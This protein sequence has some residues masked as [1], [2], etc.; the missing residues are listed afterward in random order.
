MGQESCDS[1]S[2][3]NNSYIHLSMKTKICRIVMVVIVIYIFIIMPLVASIELSKEANIKLA[4]MVECKCN[5]IYWTSLKKNVSFI[6][7]VNVYCNNTNTYIAT[8]NTFNDVNY[9]TLIN[10]TCW[11]DNTTIVFTKNISNNCTTK[12]T[13]VMTEYHDYLIVLSP[14]DG[15]SFLTITGDSLPPRWITC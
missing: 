4:D 8:I 13:N 6:S 12:I 14:P 1:Q 7:M 2:T 9:T 11:Y 15:I 3:F 5:L 10:Q